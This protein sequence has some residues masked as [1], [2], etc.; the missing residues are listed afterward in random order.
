MGE[1]EVVTEVQVFRTKFSGEAPPPPEL[2]LDSV[3]A[4]EKELVWC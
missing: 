3:L 1:E 2:H 4:M